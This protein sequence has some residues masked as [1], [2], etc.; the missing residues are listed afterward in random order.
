MMLTGYR[1]A[2]LASSALERLADP[3]AV[4]RLG[5]VPLAH[6]LHFRTTA[7]FAGTKPHLDAT[8]ASWRAV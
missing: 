5:L 7:E 4:A 2:V 3:A 6:A 1:A 8:D